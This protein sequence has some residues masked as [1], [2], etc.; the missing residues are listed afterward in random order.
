MP[1][2]LRQPASATTA[3]RNKRP[4]FPGY[5][6]APARSIDVAIALSSPHVQ[7]LVASLLVVVAAWS[8]AWADASAEAK[9]L[10]DE[11]RALV[12]DGDYVEACARF[13]RSLVL[14]VALGTEA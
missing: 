10:F 7:R 12:K 2:R 6:G 9:K 3:T 11:G 1:S 14:E 13:E 8:S 4:T 5:V